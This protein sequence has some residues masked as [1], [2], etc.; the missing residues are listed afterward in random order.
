[1]V[2]LSSVWVAEPSCAEEPSTA[3]VSYSRDVLPIFRDNC[4]GCHQSAKSMGGL[5]MT[6]FAKF[7]GGGDQ[8]AAIVPGQ[9]DTSPLIHEITPVDGKAEMPKNGPALSEASLKTIRQWILEGAADDTSGSTVTA[10]KYDAAHPP[11][12]ARPPVITSIDVSPD[13]TKLVLAGYHETVLLDG[14]AGTLLYR[15]VGMSPRVESVRFSTDGSQIAVTAGQ[16]GLSGEVQ[17]WNVADGSLAMSQSVSFDTLF[18]ISWSPD[19]SMIGFAGTDNIVRA[20]DAK[21]GEQRVRQGIHDDWPRATVFST[22]GEFIVSAGRDM[23]VKL[24]EIATGRFIDNITSITPGALRGGVQAIARHPSRDEIIV[25][26]ADGTP[27]LYRMFRQT[28]RVIGDDSNLIHKLQEMPGRIFSVAVSPDGRFMASVSTLDGQSQIRSWLYDAPG[29][30]PENIL[31]IQNKVPTT[32]TAEERKLLEAFAIPVPQPLAIIEVPTNTLYSV[33]LDNLGH[34][35]GAGVDGKVSKWDATSGQSIEVFDVLAALNTTAPSPTSHAAVTATSSA[36]LPLL[37]ESEGTLNE[38]HRAYTESLFSKLVDAVPA[39]VELASITSLVVSPES[40]DLRAWHE[41]SQIVVTGIQA[42]GTEHDV[43]SWCKFSPRDPCV[44]IDGQGWTEPRSLGKSQID[45]SLGALMATIPVEVQQSDI[46]PV[47]FIRDVNPVLS[48]LGCNQGTCHGAQAGKNGFKLSLRG[49]DPIFDLRSLIDDLGA[50]R[51]NFASPRDS[52]ILAK[53]L[54]K[55]PHVGGKLMTLGDRYSAIVEKW[56]HDGSKLDLNASRVKSIVVLPSNPTVDQPGIPRQLRVVATFHDGSQRDVTREAFIESGN[57]EVA[58]ILPKANVV[59]LRRGEAPLLA[60]Y[61][62][63]YAA[64]TLT[65]MGDRKGFEW[66][67]PEI[68]TPIDSMI[69]KKWEQVKTAPSPLSSDAEFLRRVYLDIVGL[70]PTADQVR[71]FLADPAP[72]GA[73]RNAV[74]DQLLESPEYV[75]HWTNKWSDLLQVNSKHLGKEGAQLFRDWIH[76]QV[77]DNVPYDAFVK[78]IITASGSNREN[79][80]ASYYKILRTP[81]ETLENTS[82]LFLA[83]RFNCN[84]CHDHPFERWTQD[85]YYQTAAFFSQYGLSK[86]EASGDRTIGGTA[87]EGAKPLF[88]VVADVA[89]GSVK[90]QRTGKTVEAIFPFE[91]EHVTPEGASLRTKF[92]EWLTNKSN[93]YFAKSYV[94]RL[95]GYLLGTGLIEPLDDIR[96]GN[97]ASNPEL[98]SHLEKEFIDSGFNVKHVLRA[99]TRSRVYQLSLAKNSWNGDDERNYSKAKA[100][101][102]PAEVLYDAVHRVTGSQSQLPGLPEGSRSALLAD[103]DAGLPDGFLNNLGRPVRESACECERSSDLQLG[104]IMALVGGPTIASAIAQPQNKLMQLAAQTDDNAHL[105]AELYY[106]IL[107][108][109]ATPEEISSALTLFD[110]IHRDNE[111]MQLQLLSKEAWWN[112]EFPKRTAQRLELLTQANQAKLDRE[113]EIAPHRQQMELERQDRIDK[114]QAA[115]AEYQKTIPD[116]LQQVLQDRYTNTVWQT[117]LALALSASNNAKLVPQPDRS[118]RADGNKEKGTYNVTSLPGLDRVTAVRLEALPAAEIPGGGPGFSANGNFVLTELE[119]FA[120]PKDQPDQMTKVKLSKALSDYDQP[121]LA[122]AGAIDDKNQDDGGWAIGIAG[123]VEHWAVFQLAEPLVMQPGWAIQV[124]LHQ[125]HSAADIRL[126]RFRISVTSST[127][128]IRVGLPESLAALERT[129]AADR[130]PAS[131]EAAVSYVSKVD[132]TIASLQQAVADSQK[133]LPDD[134]Q[135]LTIMKRIERASVETPVDPSVL[136]IRKDVEFSKSQ[137]Q[138]ARLTAAEDLTWALINSP[139]FLFNH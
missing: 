32:R 75:D 6:D 91:C 130:S 128:E 107:S 108:R 25:G 131:V 8:G 34:V 50:R 60:R 67:A 18:G 97:P 92:S 135:L 106:R 109:P 24:T 20:L 36:P 134:E 11:V 85:Q 98:L 30:I 65:V 55:V 129:P 99:I 41:S 94:N 119:L 80:A 139:A 68:W 96:A 93:P 121:G 57:T 122:A 21:T 45:V 27:K 138:N 53:P 49:Y 44:W 51:V 28:A 136:Q 84:K 70:P 38:L 17:V 23:T 31:A 12:Y 89:Q 26:G 43:T 69:A 74:I 73:K 7:L 1:M 39:T 61:E 64:T 115:V 47:D 16:P 10:T 90:H 137:Q 113:T 9:P 120:G 132:G 52:L 71:E 124:R 33:A 79:P 63:A 40:I 102:L 22:T 35:W 105:I 125:Y 48:R 86:D 76:K 110:R 81:E 4:W 114:A 100:R 77:T 82:H 66:I 46:G 5:V 127:E 117:Q 56:I 111:E 78:S 42:D 13:G 59:G 72:L 54:G 87:V 95:W 112:E 37:S 3:S 15:L 19:S 88:E 118:I 133:P 104:S 58:N 126:A 83:I 116:R 29:A 2:F 101:R 62:G 14:Q 123:G 103:A